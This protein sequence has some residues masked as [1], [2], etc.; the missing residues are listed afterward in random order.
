MTCG[1]FDEDGSLNWWLL[2]CI[3]FSFPLLKW[4]IALAYELAK[5]YISP[6][7]LSKY[8]RKDAESWAVVTGATDGIGLGFC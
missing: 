7:S 8:F 4:L 2:F 1:L 5:Q 3:F 6:I